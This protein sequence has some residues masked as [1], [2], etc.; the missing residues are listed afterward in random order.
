MVD[1]SADARAI[2]MCN[3]YVDDG[4][5]SCPSEVEAINILQMSREMLAESN[6]RMHKIASNSCISMQ[7][8]PPVDRA[9]D[10]K[11]LDLGVETFKGV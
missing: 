5:A 3:F 10:L 11:D 7:A 9:K 2:V 8:F 1:S 4:L 6:S